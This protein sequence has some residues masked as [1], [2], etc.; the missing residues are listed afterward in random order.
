M[1]DGGLIGAACGSD[2]SDEEEE[3]LLATARSAGVGDARG[4]PLG[5]FVATGVTGAAHASAQRVGGFAVSDA[6]TSFGLITPGASCWRSV[7]NW[8]R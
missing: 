2:V 6:G 7:V 3:T 1:L 4:A 5:T 8:A